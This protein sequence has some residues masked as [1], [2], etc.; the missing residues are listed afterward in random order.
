MEG[1]PGGLQ[2]GAGEAS[3]A[4]Q[5]S[6]G[7]AARVSAS[8]M[9]LRM[10]PPHAC[11]CAWAC[12][13]LVLQ[14]FFVGYVMGESP[15]GLGPVERGC[16]GAPR[17]L[18]APLWTP[19]LAC[20]PPPHFPSPFLP[21]PPPPPLQ[22][23]RTPLHWAAG[24]DHVHVVA[25]LLATPGVDSVAKSRVRGAQRWLSGPPVCPTPL[26]SAAGC[27]DSA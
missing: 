5:A 15:L 19:A 18:S 7:E 13:L 27:L 1:P 20:C 26:P 6:S 3:G 8:C 17:G 22:V 21:P 10:N 23:G 4:L 12:F 11:V 16:A 25:L 24:N 9:R 14:L 2:R